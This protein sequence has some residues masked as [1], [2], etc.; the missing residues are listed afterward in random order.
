MNKAAIVARV[1]TDKQEKAVLT[2]LDQAELLG[3]DWAG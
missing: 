3:R 1:S 2:V